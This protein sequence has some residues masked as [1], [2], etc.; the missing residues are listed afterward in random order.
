MRNQ[1]FHIL[2]VEDNTADVFL[3]HEELEQ[4]KLNYGLTVIGDGAEA[5]AFVRG[6]GQ[7]A[8]SPVPDI[9]VLDLNL[10][11]A[12]GIQVLRAIRHS[13]RLARVPVVITSSSDSLPPDVG[14]EQLHL[15]RYIR[16]PLELED[17]LKIGAALKE[18]LDESQPSRVAADA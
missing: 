10:P 2:L 6:E 4:A 8:A 14:A 9:A 7:Y 15:N 5:L 11:K 16:K 17:F 12:D 3:F 1:P 13:E 18:V